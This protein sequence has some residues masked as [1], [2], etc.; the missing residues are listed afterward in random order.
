MRFGGKLNKFGGKKDFFGGKYMG[1]FIFKRGAT[2]I[3]LG[4]KELFFR[5]P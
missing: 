5:G 1:A 4:G 2:K 3:F